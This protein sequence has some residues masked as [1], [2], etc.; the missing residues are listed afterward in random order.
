MIATHFWYP[1]QLIPLV[2]VCG[3]RETAPDVLAWT[4]DA[5]R[6]CGKKPA[7][8]DREIPGFIGNRLQ[9]ALL[10]E[11]WALWASGAAHGGV[12][13]RRVR[14]TIGRRLGIT[15]PIESADIAGLGTMLA[16]AEGLQPHL[17]V[18][19]LPPRGDPEASGTGRHLRLGRSATPARCAPR[20]WRSCSAGSR[21]TVRADP[22]TGAV[23]SCR[24]PRMSVSVPSHA[25]PPADDR[26]GSDQ[27]RSPGAAASR[28]GRRG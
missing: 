18:E 17:D 6:A 24:M 5:V 16:F 3:S 12:D 22:A 25:V 20:G 21:S 28:S 26:A 4:C 8:I 15:G 7:V 27:A 13:R 14:L 23:N 1:P 2:E 10:R 9:F 19:P 11:A